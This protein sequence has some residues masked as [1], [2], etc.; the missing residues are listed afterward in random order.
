M[1]KRRR[2]R[3]RK[4]TQVKQQPIQTPQSPKLDWPTIRDVITLVINAVRLF[5]P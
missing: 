3:R 1:A 4:Q 2:N 5:W